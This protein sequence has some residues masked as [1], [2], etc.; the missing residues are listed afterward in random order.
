[1][2]TPAA[3]A[4]HKSS[5]SLAAV[6]TLLGAAAAAAANARAGKTIIV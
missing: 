1:M 2:G 6:E 3:I 4:V 5:S